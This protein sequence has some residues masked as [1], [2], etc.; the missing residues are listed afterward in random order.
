MT[1]PDLASLLAAGEHAAFHG[2]PAAAVAHLEQAVVLAQS[3]GLAAEMAAA[4]WLLGV[5]LGAGGRYGA[6][7]TLRLRSLNTL[8]WA[9]RGLGQR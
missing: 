9:K 6:A 4:A 7:L 2:K 8:A 3:Q 1:T 5:A